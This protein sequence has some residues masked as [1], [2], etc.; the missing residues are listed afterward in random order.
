V[1]DVSGDLGDLVRPGSGGRKGA[2]DVGEGLARLTGEI[3][4]GD[5]VPV[6]IVGDLARDEDDAAAGGD[7]DLGVGRRGRKVLRAD[8]VQRHLR[9]VHSDKAAP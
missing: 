7:D 2:T 1:D 8:E 3:A 5:E 4:W 9:R 6:P